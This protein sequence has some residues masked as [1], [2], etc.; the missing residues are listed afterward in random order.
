LLA[1]ALFFIAP[2]TSHLRQN[3]QMQGLGTS[4]NPGKFLSALPL[5][6]QDLRKIK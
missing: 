3:F 2:D 4:K 5:P 1:R 6:L